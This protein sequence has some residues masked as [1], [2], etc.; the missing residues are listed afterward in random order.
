MPDVQGMLQYVPHV[1]DLFY[2]KAWSILKE[3]YLEM[4]SHFLT[5][6]Y[7]PLHYSSNVIQSFISKLANRL[8][9]DL[10]YNKKY[11]QN[12]HQL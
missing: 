3:S 11:L 5:Y 10:I 4:C 9:V 2:V 1:I 7:C 8:C 12:S 6:K